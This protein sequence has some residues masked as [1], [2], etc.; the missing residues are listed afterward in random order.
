MRPGRS[1]KT[2]AQAVVVERRLVP[3]KLAQRVDDNDEVDDCTGP[4]ATLSARCL[5]SSAKFAYWDPNAANVT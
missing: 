2:V 4:R 5:P 1:G 3:P